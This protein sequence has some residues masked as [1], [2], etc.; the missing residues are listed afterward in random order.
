MHSNPVKHPTTRLLLQSFRSMTP[1]PRRR[2]RGLS[3][4]VGAG[5]GDWRLEVESTAN[6]DVLAYVHH[7]DDFLTAMHDVVQGANGRH[8]VPIFNPADDDQSSLLRLVNPRADDAEV[9]IRGFDDRGTASRSVR[10]VVPAGRSRT[11]SA[12]EL[13]AGHESLQGRTAMAKGN[14]ASSSSPKCRSK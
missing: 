1:L 2:W 14:G 12:Q 4:G 5:E 3:S 8:V 9:S 13:E 10:L 11:I 7:A 6:I